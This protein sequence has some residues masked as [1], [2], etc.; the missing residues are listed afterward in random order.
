LKI[1]STKKG[2]T[3]CLS[4]FVVPLPEQLTIAEEMGTITTAIHRLP[5]QAL[6]AV[7]Q[8]FGRWQKHVAR[9]QAHNHIYLS[10]IFGQIAQ[11]Y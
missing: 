4:F 7:E 10:W 2:Q 5:Q 6:T 3:R 1:F 11:F 9:E 8:R